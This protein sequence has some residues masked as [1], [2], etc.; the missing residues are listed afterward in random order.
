MLGVKYNMKRFFI[1]LIIA[2]IIALSSCADNRGIERFRGQ[3]VEEI[4]AGGEKALSKGDWED[5]VDHFQAVQAFYPYSHYAG[6]T[7]LSIIYAYYMDD[8]YDSVLSAADRYMHLYPLG[9]HTDYALYMKGLAEYQRNWG[10]FEK[11]FAV[12]RTP[13]DLHSEDDAFSDFTLLMIRFPNSTYAPDARLRMVG[14][15]N[16]MAEHTIQIADYYYS[17]KAYVAAAQLASNVALNFQQSPSAVEGLVLM[18]KS[19]KKLSLT[20]QYERTKAVI[21]ASYP[22]RLSDVD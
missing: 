1:L 7:Q 6:E 22:D 14:I 10:F 16:M 5:A 8:D 21:A 17:M 15:R 12:D 19:Y 11:Y 20:R 18:A 9:P 2:G 13:R 4:Y 3:S